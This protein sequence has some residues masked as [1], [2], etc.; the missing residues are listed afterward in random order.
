LAGLVEEE[1]VDDD[2]TLKEMMEMEVPDGETLELRRRSGKKHSL[3]EGGVNST[4]LSDGSSYPDLRLM[5]PFEEEDEDGEVVVPYLHVDGVSMVHQMRVL[6]AA[7]SLLLDKTV[8][9]VGIEHAPDLNVRELIAFFREVQYKT[10]F[11]GARQIARIDNLCEEVLDDV[12]DHPSVSPPEPSFVRRVLMKIG[13]ISKDELRIAPKASVGAL[14][15][16]KRET[17]PFFVA[18]PR[19]RKNREEMTIQH[20]YD[21]FGG[22][23]GGGGQ[24]KTANDRKAPGK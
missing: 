4:L 20:M 1:G 21:L 17:P 6:E 3:G 8:V 11:L 2:E 23:G 24:I 12:L 14:S 13:L 16:Q 18:M 7:R 5:L 9:V 15:S 19:G 22:Y 10:F